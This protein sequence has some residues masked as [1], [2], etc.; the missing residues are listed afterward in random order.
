MLRTD[1]GCYFVRERVGLHGR[2]FAPSRTFVVTVD[3]VN[4]GSAGTDSNGAFDKSFVP[5]GLG[6]NVIQHV[7]RVTAADG[8]SSA[9]TRFTVSRRAG[10]RFLAT[11]GD[12]KTL[13]APFEAWGFATDGRRHL[14]YV[15]Y[16]SPRGRARATVALGST[17]GQCGYLRTASRRVFPFVPS[18]GT[19]TLQL[20][21]SRKYSRRPSGPVTR[22]RVRIRA[23]SADLPATARAA[24]ARYVR[25]DASCYQTG[26]RA[27]FSGAGFPARTNWRAT[28]DGSPFGNGASD[29]SGRVRGDFGVPGL[30]RRSPGEDS[31][32]LVLSDGRHSASA[33]FL[34]TRLDAS[35]SPTTG[36]PTRLRVR[37]RALGF[38][39]GSV[40]YLHYVTPRGNLRES[41]NLG[42]TSGACGHRTTPLARLF[43]FT[44]YAGVWR[45][46]FDAQRAYSPRAAPSVTIR[47]R[48][49]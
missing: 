23:A 22:I 6:A 30:R 48:I 24:V 4:F 34:V 38:G 35:F 31:H 39:R 21:T 5:G 33:V 27:T 17:G 10:G 47:Y 26:H 42:A 1:R 2:G 11:S 45:L 37:F 13:R 15:H 40:L 28:L 43:R 32:T 46:Q 9:I 41:R 49:S 29:A 14:L 8:T 16:V 36:D 44:P 18:F 12:P 19:W 20:D 3:E 25:L 7:F